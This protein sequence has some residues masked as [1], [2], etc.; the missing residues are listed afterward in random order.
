MVAKKENSKAKGKGKKGGKG[1]KRFKQA[2]EKLP[3][4]PLWDQ[5]YV[6]LGAGEAPYSLARWWKS[7]GEVRH[8]AVK[9]LAKYLGLYRAHTMDKKEKLDLA[10]AETHYINTL[11]QGY[12]NEIDVFEEL[13]VL[14][15]LQKKRL[16]AIM[17][18]ED[19]LS[20]PIE[21]TNKIA[22]QLHE[23]LKDYFEFQV[24]TGRLPRAAQRFDH[25]LALGA[26]GNDNG[27]GPEMSDKREEM[28]SKRRVAELALTLM[29]LAAK[30]KPKALPEK[31]KGEDYA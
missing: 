21:M 26:A 16:G 4:Y 28:Q 19:K 15:N 25:N 23:L 9:S 31:V 27:S 2:W 7:K 10:P 5:V 12:A 17:E 11:V 8:L 1:S 29:T 13:A 24:K 6:R 22:A 30:A 18:R 14:I 20:F 3:S